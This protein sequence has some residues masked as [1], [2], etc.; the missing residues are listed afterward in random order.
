MASSEPEVTGWLFSFG[1]Q[2]KLIEPEWVVS[3][4]KYA[5]GQIGKKYEGRKS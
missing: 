1:D 4:V 3:I 2:A 5:I